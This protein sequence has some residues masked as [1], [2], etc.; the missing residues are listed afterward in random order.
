MRCL[1]ATSISPRFPDPGDCGQKKTAKQDRILMTLNKLPALVGLIVWGQAL[2]GAP[3]A[4]PA[5][6]KVGEFN[7]SRPTSW[8][9]IEVTSPMRK[10]HLRVSDPATKESADVA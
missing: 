6:F 4:A 3:A 10:A 9:W 1:L 2:M 7:F 5:S 8:E